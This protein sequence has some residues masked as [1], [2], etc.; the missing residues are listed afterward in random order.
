MGARIGNYELIEQLGVGPHGPVHLAVDTLRDRMV[1]LKQFRSLE[2]PVK[3]G[4][5]EALTR[6]VAAHEGLESPYVGEIFSSSGAELP[7]WIVRDYI[8]GATLDTLLHRVRT[9]DRTFAVGILAGVAQGLSAIHAHG[10]VHGNLKLTNILIP[11]AGGLKLVDP[12]VAAAVLEPSPTA[13]N[14]GTGLFGMPVFLA[15]EQLSGGL[16]T[17]A[18]DMYALGVL[19]YRLLCGQYPLD[20]PELGKLRR[21]K[22]GGSYPDPR[23]VADD[24]PEE[25]ACVID[26]CLERDERARSVTATGVV[27][28]LTHWLAGRDED[29]AGALLDGAAACQTVFMMAAHGPDAKEPRPTD[30]PRA[31]SKQTQALLAPVPKPDAGKQ[32][33]SLSVPTEPQWRQHASALERS[34]QRD[35]QQTLMGRPALAAPPAGRRPSEIVPGATLEFAGVLTPASLG[36][37]ATMEQVLPPDLTDAALADDTRET[38][39]EFGTAPT[40]QRV[41]PPT[42]DVAD[43]R[44]QDRFGGTSL[45][46]P[47]SMARTHAPLPPAKAPVPPVFFSPDSDVLHDVRLPDSA[48][49]PADSGRG[50]V[51]A[52]GMLLLAAIAYGAVLYQ[53][54]DQPDPMRPP[55]PPAPVVVV[56]PEAALEAARQAAMDQ[57]APALAAALSAATLNPT[58]AEAHVLLA[59]AQL[60]SSQ[61]EAAAQSLEKAEGLAPEDPGPRRVLVQMLMD[62]GQHARASAAATT[63]LVRYSADAALH[64]LFARSLLAERKQ[65]EAS[66]ALVTATQLNPDNPDA[67]YL[68]GELRAGQQRWRDSAD[69]Y[70]RA[71]ERRPS[72]AAA[73]VGLAKS[74]L[75]LGQGG[76]TVELLVAGLRFAPDS[77]ELLFAIGRL[78]LKDGRLAE[79]LPRLLVYTKRFADDWRGHFSLGLLQLRSGRPVQAAEAFSRAIAIRP[80]QPLVHYDLGLALR[81]SGELEAAHKAFSEAVALEFSMWQAHCQRA[82]VDHRLRRHDRARQGFQQTASLN[83]GCALASA[84]AGVDMAD[85]MAQ[86]LLGLPCTADPDLDVTD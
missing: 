2:V 77:K 11:Q 19:A 8:N 13:I 22:L 40:E 18:T 27:E 35:G 38:A 58:V 4:R 41:L 17:S 71:A 25:L 30:K 82:V 15:P 80:N 57:P 23:D 16:V 74:L 5:G 66:E 61:F 49:E 29:I 42:L 63:G 65:D 75:A 7:V 20:E 64:L 14:Y 21:L 84:M 52:V 48:G 37:D 72:F 62:Q 31:L 81:A 36:H 73:Y 53:D 67:W 43:V 6:L 33:D 9:L 50:Y 34:R 85:G 12:G 59:Q 32:L 44:P 83:T 45:E 68:L 26:D 76:Q 70:R 39:T 47:A 10:A 46:V 24:L 1:A 60:R 79:A 28:L 3:N 86:M 56:D 55:P 69:C 54:K 78:Q 51:M